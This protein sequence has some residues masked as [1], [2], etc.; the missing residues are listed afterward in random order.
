M[1]TCLWWDLKRESGAYYFQNKTQRLSEVIAGF[2]TR[3]VTR[4]WNENQMHEKESSSLS[5]HNMSFCRWQMRF[6]VYPPQASSAMKERMIC[7]RGGRQ[8]RL[9]LIRKKKSV[10]YLFFPTG[11]ELVSTVDKQA[12]AG[13]RNQHKLQRRRNHQLAASTKF[14]QKEQKQEE[15]YMLL[16]PVSWVRGLFP[17]VNLGRS[18]VICT[19][20][21]N[22]FNP[23]SH[24]PYSD[25]TETQWE[26]QYKQGVFK[27]FA[28]FLHR[29]FSGGV[30]TN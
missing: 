5:L 28:T 6:I 11:E 19:M 22:L 10:Y 3:P 1:Q 24:F 7:K 18:M 21:T 23:S 4:C 29:W 17:E 25:S 16:F 12:P 26:N 2:D 8:S 9:A 14:I 20:F 13:Q 27:I 30:R 15:T